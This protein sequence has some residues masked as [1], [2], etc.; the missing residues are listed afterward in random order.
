MECWN[1]TEFT[2][3]HGDSLTL[4][5]SQLLSLLWN[6]LHLRQNHKLKSHL[7]KI[8][9]SFQSYNQFK[10]R[11]QI[12]WKRKK[13]S[14]FKKILTLSHSLF[15][16]MLRKLQNR[17]NFNLNQLR[18][19]QRKRLNHHGVFKNRLM[20]KFN[21]TNLKRKQN[22]SRKSWWSHHPKWYKCLSNESSLSQNHTKNC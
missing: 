17:T 1:F 21:L 15:P 18:Q 12:N 14:Y 16:Q 5:K 20:A 8:I 6:L 13:R 3:T 2:M 4:S 7:T 11:K 19:S 22:K 9:M 10:S